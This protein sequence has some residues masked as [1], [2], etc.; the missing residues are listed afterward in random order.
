MIALERGFLFSSMG[1]A[2]FMVAL[3]E[4][5]FRQAAGWMLILSLLAWTGVIH[6]YAFSAGGIVSRFG[7][8]VAP[9]F[10]L[11]YAAVAA[12][13]LLLGRGAGRML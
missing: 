1:L 5:K 9:G 7:F 2:A 10:A 8:G 6:G 12:L 11:S 3:L 13:C 4:R